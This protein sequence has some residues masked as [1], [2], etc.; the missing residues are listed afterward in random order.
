[1][2]SGRVAGCVFPVFW[3]ARDYDTDVH[4]SSCAF[5]LSFSYRNQKGFIRSHVHNRQ[6]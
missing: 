5:L 4:V 3:D 6:L 1:M 2:K